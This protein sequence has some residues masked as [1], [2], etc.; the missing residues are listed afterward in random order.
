MVALLRMVKMTGLFHIFPPHLPH[1]H[2]KVTCF[3]FYFFLVLIVDFTQKD[4]TGKT[5]ANLV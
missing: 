5:T 4:G 3:K 1:L 2:T